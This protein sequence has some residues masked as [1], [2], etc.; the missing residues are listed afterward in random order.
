MKWKH[1]LFVSM[2]IHLTLILFVAWVSCCLCNQMLQ[3]RWCCCLLK[4]ISIN[5]FHLCVTTSTRLKSTSCALFK[6]KIYRF[7]WMIWREPLL[8][9]FLWVKLDA[10]RILIYANHL[11][12]CLNL[13]VE[14]HCF[15]FKWIICLN[16]LLLNLWCNINSN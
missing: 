1:S 14:N 9:E 13:H 15:R 12:I 4:L 8:C 3:W 5:T 2:K 10:G 7:M 16:L 6:Y 11:A